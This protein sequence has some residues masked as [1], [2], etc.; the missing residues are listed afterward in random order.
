MTRLSPLAL[1]ARSPRKP[2]AADRGPGSR[3]AGLALPKLPGGRGAPPYFRCAAVDASGKVYDGA[4][5]G[6][7]L[8]WRS[9]D[10][11]RVT[12]VG[13]SAVCTRDSGGALALTAGPYLALPASVRA[14]CGIRG[15]DRVL[16]AADPALGVLAVHPPA[17]VASMLAAFHARLAGG[18]TDG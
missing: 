15:G 8:G 13:A 7:V 17:A 14:R 4:A 6:G 3:A 1:P 2:P 18:D 5:V 10:R 12:V 16:L 9:G 11:L